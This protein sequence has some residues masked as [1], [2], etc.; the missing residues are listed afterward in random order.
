MHTPE[1]K[2]NKIPKLLTVL[3]ALLIGLIDAVL[4]ETKLASI[5]PLK[6]E[7][8]VFYLIVRGR[9]AQTVPSGF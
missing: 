6:P 8:F 2:W 4:S 1:N 5:F 7:D 3:C 9:S